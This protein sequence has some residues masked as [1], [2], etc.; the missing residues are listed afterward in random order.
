MP[1]PVNSSMAAAT[2]ITS[3]SSS[4]MQTANPN[5]TDTHYGP[6]GSVVNSYFGGWSTESMVIGWSF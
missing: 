6:L 3:R 2:G 1:R 5:A 4:H